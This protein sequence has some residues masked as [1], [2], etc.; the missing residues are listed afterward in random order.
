MQATLVLWRCDLAGFRR[1]SGRDRTGFLLVLEWAVFARATQGQVGDFP[2][3]AW[4][5]SRA[6]DGPATLGFAVASTSKWS[7]EKA[8]P[9]WL[10]RCCLGITILAL[11][12][13]VAI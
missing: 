3:T 8:R 2:V 13:A 7:F 9:E 10:L 4:V 12:A 5:R 1:L 11:L 6:R